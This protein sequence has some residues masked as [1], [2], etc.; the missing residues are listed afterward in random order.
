MAEKLRVVDGE[1]VDIQLLFDSSRL[2]SA[3]AP[4]NQLG[5]SRSRE[6]LSLVIL[7]PHLPPSTCADSGNARQLASQLLLSCLGQRKVPHD[8]DDEEVH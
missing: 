3:P 5:A 1:I 8:G 2:P 7:C 4:G 6:E